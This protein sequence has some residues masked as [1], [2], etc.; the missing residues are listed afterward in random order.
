MVIKTTVGKTRFPLE[1]PYLKYGFRWVN[2]GLRTLC[3]R[4][5]ENRVFAGLWVYTCSDGLIM[6]FV[7]VKTGF[8]HKAGFLAVSRCPER[9][10]TC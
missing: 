3:G 5:G 2:Y 9:T 4:V 10:K 7:R 8:S 1:K 6:G